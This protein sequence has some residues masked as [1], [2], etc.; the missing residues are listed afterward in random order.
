MPRVI[1]TERQPSV[2]VMIGYACAYAAA[3]ASSCPGVTSISA[4]S[5]TMTEASHAAPVTAGAGVFPGTGRRSRVGA[6]KHGGGP[7]ARH[8]LFGGERRRRLTVARTGHREWWALGVAGVLLIAGLRALL[9]RVTDSTVGG[10]DSS[11][12]RA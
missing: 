5:R 4:T 7:H 2:P 11:L 10:D 6:R 1:R 9:D 3:N 8:S 12:F